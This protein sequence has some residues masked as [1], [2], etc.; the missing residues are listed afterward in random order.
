MEVKNWTGNLYHFTYNSNS[1]GIVRGKVR[2]LS[3]RIAK[4]RARKL[5]GNGGSLRR[6]W[7][8]RD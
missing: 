7:E 1:L 5:V 8:M 3:V 6:I 4:G 2:A